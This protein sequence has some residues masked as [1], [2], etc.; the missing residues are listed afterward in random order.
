M[1]LRLK[2]TLLLTTIVGTT[3]LALWIILGRTIIQPFTRE[4]LEIYLDEVV[5]VAD[6]ITEGAKPEDLGRELNLDVRVF[7][8]EPPFLAKL[9]Q[10][11]A[12]RCQSEARGKYVITHC[13]GRRAPVAVETEAGWIVVRRDID[14]GA[15]GKRIGQL[16]L[17]IAL[18]VFAVSAAI[19]TVITRPLKTTKEAMERIALG[20]LA[21]RLPVSG[22]RELQEAA[23]AFNTMADRVDALLR[24]ERELM[25]GISHEL[26]TPLARLRVQLELFRDLAEAGPPDAKRL[27]TMEAD[28]EEVD[29]LIGELLECSRLQLGERRIELLPVDL[30]KVAGDAAERCPLPKHKLVVDADHPST[31]LGDHAR[32][33]R[34]VG[35]LLQNAGKYAP[36]GS[37]IRV[38]V[39]GSEIEVLD[40][41]PGV[42]AEDLDRMFEPFFRGAHARSHAKQGGLGLGLMIARQI[43]TLHGG[44]I[45]AKNREDGGL[46]IKFS[47]PR[48]S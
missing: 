9:T 30:R 4:V 45:T 12:A 5:F 14:I 2:L 28:L 26:R 10:R 15:P 32:L 38:V 6:R 33:V 3:L 41:G 19:A 39:R 13:K 42:T 22:G 1:S 25:A 17:F 47:L 21:H 23:R 40:R 36:E 7:P 18:F 46:A 20:D 44:S 8:R 29:M 48:S 43:V 34:V 16:L 31:V 27:A 35:N 24:T 11:R 37:E